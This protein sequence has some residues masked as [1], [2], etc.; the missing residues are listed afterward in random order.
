MEGWNPTP[1]ELESVR[2]VVETL[3]NEADAV[4]V[5][6]VGTMHRSIADELEREI[7]AR[8]A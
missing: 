8:S 1:E 7:S 3:R 2:R 4:G 6:P 5:L